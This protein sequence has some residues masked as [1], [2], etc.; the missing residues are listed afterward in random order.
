LMSSTRTPLTGNPLAVFTDARPDR[1][2]DANLLVATLA[3]LP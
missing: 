2:G 3:T 1:Q